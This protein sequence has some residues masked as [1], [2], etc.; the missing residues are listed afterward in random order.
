LEFDLL[1]PQRLTELR[2]LRAV[3]TAEAENDHLIDTLQ[4]SLEIID[5]E[6]LDELA[7]GGFG[8]WSG[9]LDGSAAAWD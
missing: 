5:E 8:P 3:E 2:G 1:L 6:I 7:H 9:G 4:A